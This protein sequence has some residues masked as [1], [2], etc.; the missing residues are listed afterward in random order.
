M[1]GAHTYT[2]EWTPTFMKFSVDGQ[3]LRQVTPADAK[4]GLTW[5][6]TP[7]RVKLGTWVGGKPPNQGT[8]DWAGG[9]VDWSQAPF[10]GIYKSIKITDYGAGQTGAKEYVYGD[11]SG[12]WQSI[13]I[14]G[15]TPSAL[16]DAPTALTTAAT[17]TGKAPPATT[18]S[19]QQSSLSPADGNSSTTNPRTST[20]STSAP[21]QT[22]NSA[23]VSRE[24]GSC[25]LAAAVFFACL[26]LWP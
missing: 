4:N 25:S 7:M 22:P 16:P 8:I 15:G 11:A 9:L 12:A 26:L 17:V 10:T 1:T 3:V 13:K 20:T 19:A 18:I 2:L 5:P 24:K 21:L 6:Q 14:I 23:L